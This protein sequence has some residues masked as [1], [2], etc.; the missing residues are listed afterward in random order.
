MSLQYPQFQSVIRMTHR[1]QESSIFIN[2]SFIVKNTNQKDQPDEETYRIRL[3]GNAVR[4]LL[5]S[6]NQGVSP[7]QHIDVFTN[8]EVPLEP[9]C[10]E[11][12]LTFI[13]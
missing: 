2:Y 6:W 9:Q 4:S 12:L 3:R 7:A 1:T 8:Q 5:L 11:F 13:M 10:L